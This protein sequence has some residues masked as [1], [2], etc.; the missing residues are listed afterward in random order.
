M[1]RLPL[2]GLDDNFR[3][4]VGQNLDWLPSTASKCTLV[5][6]YAA[7]YFAPMGVFPIVLQNLIPNKF[8]IT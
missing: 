7:P 6:V 5:F 3:A 2:V 8:N 4:A 1:W